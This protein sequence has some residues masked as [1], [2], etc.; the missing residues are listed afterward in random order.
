MAERRMI[1]KKVVYS[2][3]FNRLTAKS[4][5]LYYTMVMEADDDGLIGN[6]KQIFAH[7][8][9]NKKSLDALCDNGF[10]ICFRN[11]VTV[12]RHWHV[13]NRIPRDRYKQTFYTKELSQLE[14]CSDGTYRLRIDSEE[15]IARICN[16]KR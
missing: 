1:S 7:V 4:K 2:D 16:T 6:I 13:Q 3:N 8:G 9:A 15:V 5:L 12:I 11:G 10:A 14:I